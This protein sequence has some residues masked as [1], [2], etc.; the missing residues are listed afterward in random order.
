MVY[1]KYEPQVRCIV[2]PVLL[3]P[4]AEL[5]IASHD[6]VGVAKVMDIPLLV[7]EQVCDLFFPRYSQ[8]SLDLWMIPRHACSLSRYSRFFGWDWL[9]FLANVE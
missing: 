9:L 6:K 1:L 4:G 3:I 2:F 8:H 7:S 5:A